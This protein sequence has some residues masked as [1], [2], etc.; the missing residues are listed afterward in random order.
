MISFIFQDNTSTNGRH[1]VPIDY[2][3][4]TVT[5]GKKFTLTPAKAAKCVGAL[6]KWETSI[7]RVRWD[8][9]GAPVAGATAALSSGMLRN[10]GDEYFCSR[11]EAQGL[12]CLIDTTAGGLT[13]FMRV[14]YYG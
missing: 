8:G 11:E 4:I 6:V 1:P 3:D 12:V 13:G 7:F 5:A 10:S 14:T 2:E 9:K